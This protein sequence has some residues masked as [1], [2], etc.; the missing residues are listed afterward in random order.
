MKKP[1]SQTGSLYPA[2]P[3]AALQKRGAT[4]GS[5]EPVKYSDRW[6]LFSLLRVS[7]NNTKKTPISPCLL[8]KAN[9]IGFPS[10]YKAGSCH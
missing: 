3:Q 1:W 5:A 2:L 9:I 4:P 6:L 7:K 10:I 8:A